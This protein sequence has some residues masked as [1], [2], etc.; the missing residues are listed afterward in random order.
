MA[1]ISRDQI[2][3]ALATVQ[4]PEIRRPLTELNMIKSVRISDS[5]LVSVDIWLTVSGCPMRDEITSR[6]TDAVSKVPGVTGVTVELDVMDSD[7]RAALKEQLQGPAKD[8]PFNR[9]GNTTK[10]IAVAS[11]KAGWASLHSRPTWRLPSRSEVF[12]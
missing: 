10:I 3:A 5:G 6:V 7:Q 1:T 2:D 12:R 9:P 11:G 4:D 8:N